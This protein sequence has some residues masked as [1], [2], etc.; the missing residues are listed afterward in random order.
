MIYN[1]KT[2]E[3]LLKALLELEK[4]YEDLNSSYEKTLSQL[5]QA[6]KTYQEKENVYRTLFDTSNDAVFIMEQDRFIDCNYRA[7]DLFKCT[8]EDLIGKTPLHYSPHYQ[9]NGLLSS[10]VAKEKVKLAV[11]GTPQ[12]FEW[13][14]QKADGELFEAEVSLFRIYIKNKPYLQA[15][16]RDISYR[17]KTEEELRI[18]NLVF[19]TAISASSIADKNGNLLFVN[20]SFLKIWGYDTKEEIIGKPI[21]NFI[22]KEQDA[23]KIVKS[24]NNYD[25]WEGEYSALRKDGSTFIA[26]SQAT[27][28]R[29]RN[30]DIIGYQSAVVD[31]TNRKKTE[32]ALSKSEENYK[33]LIDFA[34]D[35]FFQGNTAGEFLLANKK[36]IELTGY[37]REE[38][39]TMGM[40]DLFPKEALE[41]SPLRFDLL[42]EG[43]SIKSE[44]SFLTKT[45]ELVP[46]EMYSRQMPD[47]TFQSFIRDISD[48]KLFEKT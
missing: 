33:M 30:N 47:G 14:H 1:D 36:A 7:L 27:S 22:E 38:L 2:R 16:V 15:I 13:V 45:G 26:F 40:Q 44:R 12:I 24:L 41:L 46:I 31:I 23:E 29:D 19:D 10:D 42:R 35:A 18:K 43:R 3:E 8:N 4:K 32:E 39:L 17:V 34:S 11:E 48:R 37:S 21:L 5:K 25:V 20:D 6:N 28:L 9:P